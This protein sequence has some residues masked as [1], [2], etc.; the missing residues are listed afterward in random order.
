MTLRVVPG[1]DTARIGVSCVVQQ[2]CLIDIINEKRSRH[3]MWLVGVR[4]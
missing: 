4:T 2:R 3:Y 1:H